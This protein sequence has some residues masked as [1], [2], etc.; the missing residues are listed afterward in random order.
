[1]R[2]HSVVRGVAKTGGFTGRYRFRMDPDQVSKDA[3]ARRLRQSSQGIDCA[4][5]IH[6]S[7]HI[8]D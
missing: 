8:D 2:R 4:R 3:H 1:M 6:M 7:G 5:F